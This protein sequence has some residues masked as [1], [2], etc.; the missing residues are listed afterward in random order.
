LATQHNLFAIYGVKEIME[1]TEEDYVIIIL[2]KKS[3]MESTF[4]HNLVRTH[5]TGFRLKLRK[6]RSETLSL[7]HDVLIWVCK[8][9]VRRDI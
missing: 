2:S 6:V 1:E 8:G 3:H 7:F 9:G 4:K 5:E